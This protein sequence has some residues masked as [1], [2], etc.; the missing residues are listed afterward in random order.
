[1]KR[2]ET[3]SFRSL[4]PLCKNSSA[5]IF[6]LFHFGDERVFVP[7]E[8]AETMGEKLPHNFTD[9][10]L[11]RYQQLLGAVDSPYGKQCC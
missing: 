5:P 9:R 6:L 8:P 1:M 11:P 10:K 7:A 4:K 3:K 2:V